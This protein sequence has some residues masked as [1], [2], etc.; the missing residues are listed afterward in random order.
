MLNL[1]LT[2]SLLIPMNVNGLVAQHGYNTGKRG[3][4]LAEPP[5]L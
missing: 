3:R 5:K 4:L 1:K 2:D